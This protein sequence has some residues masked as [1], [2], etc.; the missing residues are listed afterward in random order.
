MSPPSTQDVDGV[1]VVR[2]DDP[3][4]LNEVPSLWS[5]EA[6]Y[7]EVRARQC[8][9]VVVDLVGIDYISS[10]G[11]GALV[12][13]LRRVQN[14]GGRLGLVSVHP[15]VVGVLTGIHLSTLLPIFADFEAAKDG[16]MRSRDDDGDRTSP[17][18]SP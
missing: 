5:R 6:I 9:L 12:G 17:P 7:N 4:S 1:L 2:F 16:L 18:A 11:I 15:Y 14:Q 3:A 10:L 8:P 13:L